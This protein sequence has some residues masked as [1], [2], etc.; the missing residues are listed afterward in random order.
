MYQRTLGCC[1]DVH[2]MM[3]VLELSPKRKVSYSIG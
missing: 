1:K 2:A 3:G